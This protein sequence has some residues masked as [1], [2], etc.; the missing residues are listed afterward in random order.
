MMGEGLFSKLAFTGHEHLGMGKCVSA[1]LIEC[2]KC[3]D[4]NFL[5]WLKSNIAM[6][7][8]VELNAVRSIW[9]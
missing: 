7:G 5:G 9:E 4:E 6:M 8:K 2:Y 1:S 3:C